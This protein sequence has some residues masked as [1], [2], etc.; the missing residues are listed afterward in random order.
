[1]TDLVEITQ[2][3]VELK[4]INPKPVFIAVN[5]LVEVCGSKTVEEYSRKVSDV[6]TYRTDLG[7]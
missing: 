4:G 5:R 2:E 6:S 1:M 7:V 3:Y